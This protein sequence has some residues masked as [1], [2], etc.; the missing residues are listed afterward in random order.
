MKSHAGAWVSRLPVPPLD[1]LY[2][3]PSVYSNFGGGV[4]GMD[5]IGE[6]PN[7]KQYGMSGGYSLTSLTDTIIFN[8]NATLR[9]FTS[10]PYSDLLTRV[11]G[12]SSL[13]DSL[14][15]FNRIPPYTTMYAHKIGLIYRKLYT[16]EE[17]KLVDYSIN[18]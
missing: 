3:Q 1:I 9:E 7:N 10:F 15:N 6:I 5:S 14:Q 4:F 13:V 12:D 8:T 11:S 16:G 17:W 18:H 2:Y